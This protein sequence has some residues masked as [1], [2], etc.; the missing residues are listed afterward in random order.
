VLPEREGI[1]WVRFRGENVKRV[2]SFDCVAASRCD[3]ATPL[4]GC[5]FFDVV[6]KSML[7]TK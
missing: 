3:A 6:K 5:D 2:G 4:R 1:V 7:Q